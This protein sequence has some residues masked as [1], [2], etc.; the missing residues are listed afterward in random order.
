MIRIRRLTL[1]AAY[2]TVLTVAVGMF[3]AKCAL[4][5]IAI[6]PPIR[7]YEYWKEK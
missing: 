7:T 1:G 2:E 6:A 5:M 3:T 4:L